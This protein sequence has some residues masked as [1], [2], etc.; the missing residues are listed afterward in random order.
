[1]KKDLKRQIKQDEF[2]SGIE[3]VVKFFEAH[4]EEVRVT[5]IALV[6]VGA[7]AWGFAYV[8]GRRTREA[9]DALSEALVTFETPVAGQTP[10]ADGAVNPP[11]PSADV[12]FKKAAAGFDGVARRYS[13][14]PIAL[15]ARYY[16][17]LCRIELGDFDTARK[18]LEAI[19]A[20]KDGGGGLTSALARMA[21]ADLLKRRGHVEEAV[22]A[23]RA[24]ANDQGLPLPR[25]YALWNVAT[26]LEEAGHPAEAAVAYRQLRDEFP[27]SVWA[28]EAGRMASYLTGGKEE[29]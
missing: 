28:T 19:A 24:L 13:T 29:G 1:L 17:A 16:A 3:K 7:L 20:Q 11:F 12:K 21:L 10:P 9:S 2:L 8:Q 6:V 25:D 14:Q 15:R 27:S 26:T 23:Y 4:K 5:T 22:E 18:D